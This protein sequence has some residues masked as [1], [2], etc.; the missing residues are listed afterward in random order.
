MWK[1]LAAAVGSMFVLV[2]CG[3][4]GEPAP[5]PVAPAAKAPGPAYKTKPSPTLAAIKARGH[6]NCGVHPGLAGFAFRD[7][8]GTWRGF[9]VDICRAVAAATLGDAKAV[10]YSAISAQD[11]FSALQ[12]GQ[13]DILSRNTSWTFARD[14]GLG[15]DFPVITYYDGQGFMV[16]KALLLS[17]ADELN[18]ARICVQA[19][20]A[21][22][23]NLAD[24]FRARGLKYTPVVVASEA[25]ARNAYQAEKCDAFT[26]DVAAL[27][28]ARSVMNSPGAHVILPTVISKEP[29]GPVVRQ[30]DPV[31]TDIVRWTV[32]ALVLA[33]EYGLDSKT[34]PE[35]LKTS[36]DVRVRR[37][38]GAQD[39]FGPMLGLSEDWAYRAIVQVGAYDEVFARN[40]GP[41]SAL[42]LERGHN[43]LWNAAPPGLLYA[44]PVR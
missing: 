17:S 23:A 32:Y 22:E 26:A 10:R 28:S 43:A 11:R 31:W 24:Y 34:A 15:L 1:R 42:R 9:D 36:T 41:D 8:R 21:S 33:E 44:P 2:G 39:A 38:L 4:G 14:A 19:G 25:D 16:P 30:D 27:A 7:D 6:L 5:T 35:A 40:V 29:L 37:L 13:I 18:G 12:A 20:T 3:E